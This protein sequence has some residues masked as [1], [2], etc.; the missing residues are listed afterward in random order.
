MNSLVI[1]PYASPVTEEGTEAIF[2]NIIHLVKKV[3]SASL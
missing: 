1:L 2:F 3:F